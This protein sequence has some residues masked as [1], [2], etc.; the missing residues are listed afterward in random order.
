M[1]VLLCAKEWSDVVSLAM[2]RPFERERHWESRQCR[3]L[4]EVGVITW[5]VVA[6]GWGCGVGFTAEVVD[7]SPGGGHSQ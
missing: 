6:G 2:V 1:F 4:G 5:A 7:W 3:Y